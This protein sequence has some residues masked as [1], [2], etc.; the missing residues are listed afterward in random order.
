MKQYLDLV[1]DVFEDGTPK[2]NRTEIPTPYTVF[3]RQIRFDLSEGLPVLTTKKMAI[4][5]CVAELL[6]FISGSPNERELAEI[7][8]GKSREELKDKRT[9]WSD[10]YEAWTGK[11]V[12]EVPYANLGCVYG[13][14]WRDFIVEGYYG[15]VD[16]FDQLEWLINELKSN[17][18][19][20]KLIM[21]SYS[22][23]QISHAALTACHTQVQFQVQNGKLNCMWTQASV[24]LFLGLP[25]NIMSYAIL[26]HMLAKEVGL[27]VGELIGSLGDVH[28][29][30][31]AVDNLKEQ[32]SREPLP[33][34]KLWLNPEKDIFHYTVDDVKLIDYQ[35]HGPLKAKMAV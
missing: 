31:N 7:Q 14:Q 34:P 26:T 28:I 18:N 22:P 29:Y 17:P 24:D 3:G 2:P 11:K 4:K 15:Y 12:S 32:L 1:K 10:N 6:W 9:I 5:A 13:T 8:Y 21:L 23:A 33:L 19:S 25:F 35:S 27:E 20:R 16:G 30:E